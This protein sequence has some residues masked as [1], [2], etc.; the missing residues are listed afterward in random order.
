MFLLPLRNIFRA[1]DMDHTG[2][3]DSEE[4]HDL[5][6]DYGY[7]SSEEAISLVQKIDTDNSGKIDYT[8]SP[9]QGAQFQILDPFL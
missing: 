8:E 4:L 9:R 1:C 7:L 6:T 2:F 5:L 3:L